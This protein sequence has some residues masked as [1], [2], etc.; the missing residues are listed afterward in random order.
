M[1]GMYTSLFFGMVTFIINKNKRLGAIGIMLTLVAGLHHVTLISVA[2]FMVHMPLQ[3]I[4]LILMT[5]QLICI[6][7]VT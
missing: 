4:L 2:Q 5:V 3:E 7:M 6:L 1:Y